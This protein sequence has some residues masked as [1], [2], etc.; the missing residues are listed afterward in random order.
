M[1]K[2]TIYFRW[3]QVWVCVITV[4]ASRK[5]TDQGPGRHESGIIDIVTGTSRVDPH[6]LRTSNFR[7]SE[8]MAKRT[9][10]DILA[11]SLSPKLEQP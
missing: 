11:D 1:Y 10:V 3:S 8:G 4:E 5:P 9:R 6:L 7:A 2:G